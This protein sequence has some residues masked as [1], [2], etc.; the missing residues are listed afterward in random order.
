MGEDRRGE[1]V[2]RAERLGRL[3]ADGAVAAGGPDPRDCEGRSLLPTGPL[4]GDFD[5]LL[6]ELGDGAGEPEVE[7]A[8][9]RAYRERLA[10]ALASGET[11]G[12]DA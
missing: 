7:Q 4:E 8:F 11:G 5:A 3:C 2:A 12:A 9:E 10:A 1:M 6:E